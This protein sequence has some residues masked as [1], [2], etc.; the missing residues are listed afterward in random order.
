MLLTDKN[1]RAPIVVRMQ[2]IKLRKKVPVNIRKLL[3]EKLESN[4]E[5][6]SRTTHQGFVYLIEIGHNHIPY[7]LIS[8]NSLPLGE[9]DL[10]VKPC[11][12]PP[13]T[14]EKELDVLFTELM[15]NVLK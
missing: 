5:D 15:N 14:T 13:I 4:P 1:P 7:F 10:A 11:D 3:F 6:L 12:I 9:Q 2:G 8:N